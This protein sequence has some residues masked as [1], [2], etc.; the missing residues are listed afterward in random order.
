MQILLEKYDRS[1]LNRREITVV[2]HWWNFLE[3]FSLELARNLPAVGFTEHYCSMLWRSQALGRLQDPEALSL[4]PKCLRGGAR[5]REKLLI[6]GCYWLPCTA[7]TRPWKS[8]EHCRS[9]IP[10]KAMQEEPAKQAHR[11]QEGSLFS[12]CNISPAPSTEKASVPAGKGKKVKI[13]STITEQA[14]RVNLKLRSNKLTTST[15]GT[16]E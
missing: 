6:T 16:K 3:T 4:P 14:E 15:P 7:R 13:C 9:L 8:C 11:N 5:G 12:S 2:L 1:S 10:E